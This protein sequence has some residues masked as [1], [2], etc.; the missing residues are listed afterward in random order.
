L[1][2]CCVR[3]SVGS[4]VTD[5]VTN[6]FERLSILIGLNVRLM[7]RGDALATRARENSLIH[8]AAGC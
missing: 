3:Q 4:V 1:S 5:P 6:R 2:W 7:A 8:S